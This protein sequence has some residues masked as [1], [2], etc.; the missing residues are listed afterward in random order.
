[1]L[2]QVFLEVRVCVCVHLWVYM[3]VQ[4]SWSRCTSVTSKGSKK[5]LVSGT[6]L[7]QHLIRFLSEPG[8]LV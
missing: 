5:I 4:K 8:L 2:S 3:C 1:M 6:D 7:V